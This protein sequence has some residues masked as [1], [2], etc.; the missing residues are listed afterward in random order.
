MLFLDDLDGRTHAVSYGAT[1]RTRLVGEF[2]SPVARRQLSGCIL[3]QLVLAL[4][5]AAGSSAL[6]VNRVG[7]YRKDKEGC[8]KAARSE[9]VE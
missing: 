8:D 9:Q 2:L 7:G 6:V 1:G 5:V 4:R 3:Y